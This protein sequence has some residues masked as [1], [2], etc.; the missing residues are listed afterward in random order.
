MIPGIEAYVSI[1]PHQG[2]PHIVGEAGRM[3]QQMTDSHRSPGRPQ[4]WLPGRIETFE[5]LGRCE[6][7]HQLA[8][9]LLEL[10]LVALDQL[11][12]RRRRHRLGHRGDPDY[13]I[14]RHRRILAEFTRAEGAF[15]H[16]ALIRG[17][18]RHDARNIPGC[19]GPTQHLIDALSIDHDSPPCA[20]RVN[21]LRLD[22]VPVQSGQLGSGATL[23]RMLAL[24]TLWSQYNN[25]QGL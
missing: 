23:K 12:R 18:H 21:H 8:R 7:C 22:Q 1:L 19:G 25:R 3:G 17:G 9:R 20:P 16:N 13:G 6:F 24:P 2:A 14:E 5:H 4:T 11:H 15:I 10:D